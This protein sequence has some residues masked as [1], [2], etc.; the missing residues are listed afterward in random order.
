M[1]A[2]VTAWRMARWF[3]FAG[4]LLVLWVALSA[5]EATAEPAPKAL[6]SLGA[7]AFEPA[8]VARPLT[9]TTAALGEAVRSAA[10]PLVKVAPVKAVAPRQPR[11][12]SREDPAIGT[13]QPVSQQ[14]STPPKLFPSNVGATSARDQT[15]QAAAASTQAL[16][17]TGRAADGLLAGVSSATSRTGLDAVAEPVVS[18]VRPAAAAV[19]TGVR[20]AVIQ[21]TDVVESAPLP[22]LD[23]RL[24]PGSQEPGHIQ[25]IRTPQTLRPPV[26][27]PSEG[28]GDAAGLGAD[29]IV[30][31][32]VALAPDSSTAVFAKAGPPTSLNAGPRASSGQRAAVSIADG[33]APTTPGA[34]G[35]PAALGLSSA[36]GS[37]S[38]APGGPAADSVE[39]LRLP[40]LL[41]NLVSPDAR[42]EFS[43][44]QPLP[45][46]SPE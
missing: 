27:V 40:S 3:A 37:G 1:G 38:S 13:K 41:S 39:A 8:S 23:V 30:P 22:V 46:F 17:S 14:N 34:P 26:A 4:L 18:A 12:T 45:G 10:T 28:T 25:P 42:T 43:H 29:E 21:V 16:R 9:P 36:A 44:R 11:A 19:A 32:A 5:Q 33:G 2:P 24:I 20:A 6:E 7:S 31:V 15:Q 35:S